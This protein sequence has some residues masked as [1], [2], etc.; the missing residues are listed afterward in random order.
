MTT[1]IILTELLLIALI[2][3]FTRDW[4]LGLFRG[5]DPPGGR[6][7]LYLRIMRPQHWILFTTLFVFVAFPWM[8]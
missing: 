2:M 4:E 1:L 5:E 7:A 6:I 8:R 3:Y